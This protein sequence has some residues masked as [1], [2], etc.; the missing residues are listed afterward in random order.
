VGGGFR[1][2]AAAGGGF[3]AEAD[4][5]EFDFGLA[6]ERSLPAG[7]VEISP[8]GCENCVFRPFYVHQCTSR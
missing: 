6:E 7:E 4:R 8:Q 3:S 5:L 2:G 1:C